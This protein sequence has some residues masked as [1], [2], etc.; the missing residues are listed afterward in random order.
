MNINALRGEI[1]RNGLTQAQ[2]AKAIGMSESTFYRRIKE[3]DFGLQEVHSMIELL[4]I[5]DP[6]A[7]FLS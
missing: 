6:A 2:V 1:A 7:I 4:H 5:A 3:Q